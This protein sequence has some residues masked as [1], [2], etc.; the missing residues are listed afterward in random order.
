MGRVWDC[1]PVAE[2]V[3]NIADAIEFNERR[4]LMRDFSLLVRHVVPI[5]DKHMILAVHADAANLAGDP[6]LG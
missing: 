1:L 5:N 6:I 4:S 3:H 2:A